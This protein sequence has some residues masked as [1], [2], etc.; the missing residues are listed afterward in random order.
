MASEALIVTSRGALIADRV[1]WARSAAER[2]RGLLGRPALES[3]QA[4]V[5]D[6]A[7]QVHTFGMRYAID[8]VF[9]DRDWKVVNVAR[10]MKPMRVGRWVPRARYAIELPAGAAQVE[11]GETLTVGGFP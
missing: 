10:E 7:R 1:S 3:G 2:S 4:L 9:C 11:V 5:L 6:R 8:V